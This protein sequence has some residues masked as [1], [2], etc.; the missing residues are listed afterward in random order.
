MRPI[1]RLDYFRI[2]T[3]ECT[4]TLVNCLTLVCILSKLPLA[5]ESSPLGFLSAIQTLSSVVKL[6]LSMLWFRDKYTNQINYFS[7]ALV[8]PAAVS[9]VSQSKLDWLQAVPGTGT[10]PTRHRQL[11]STG[12]GLLGRRPAPDRQLYVCQALRVRFGCNILRASQSTQ[13][14]NFRNIFTIFC[15]LRWTT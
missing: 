2:V 6:A 12:P 11:G 10:V 13:S 4:E 7:L 8:V 15:R 1:L 9:S 14:P 5:F 3:C